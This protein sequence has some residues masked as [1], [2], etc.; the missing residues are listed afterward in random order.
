LRGV[1]CHFAGGI[2]STSPSLSLFR[3]RI[4]PRDFPKD[5]SLLA[6]WE[7]KS[8]TPESAQQYSRLNW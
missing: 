7:I 3:R 8:P 6:A 5:M 4:F 1:A 2:S